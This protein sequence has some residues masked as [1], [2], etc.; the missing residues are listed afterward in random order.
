MVRKIPSVSGARDTRLD[1]QRPL[2]VGGLAGRA[3]PVYDV[4]RAIARPRFPR[5]RR[6]LVSWEGVAA[7]SGHVWSAKAAGW[8]RT[9][10]PVFVLAV[11]GCTAA[12][13]GN[14]EEAA[15]TVTGH[16]VW[17]AEVNA[18]SLCGSEDELWVTAAPALRDS[19]R[20]RYESMDLPPYTPVV[21]E[22][23]GSVGPVLDCGFCESYDG[24]FAID[25]IV[26]WTPALEEECVSG[27]LR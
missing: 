22:V 11:M 27:L 15:P 19:L 20:A 25:E 26:T 6:S 16:Y 2:S 7:G 21:I 14:V 24:S 12:P 5:A 17:G 3:P 4:R 13:D 10:T 23:R 1:K 8:M 18:F 9:F